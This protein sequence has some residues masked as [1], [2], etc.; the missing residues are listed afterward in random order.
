MREISGQWTNK[1]INKATYTQAF[2]QHTSKKSNHIYSGQDNENQSLT[3][4]LKKQ[5]KTDTEITKQQ[6]KK[7]SASDKSSY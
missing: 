3:R 7:T 2:R 6:L 1:E 4:H 5:S